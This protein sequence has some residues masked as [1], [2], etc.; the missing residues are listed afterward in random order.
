MPPIRCKSDRMMQINYPQCRKIKDW[1]RRREWECRLF[2]QKSTIK[3]VSKPMLS[4][5]SFDSGAFEP[6]S[7]GSS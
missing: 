5:A 3:W 6:L 1:L 2:T 7:P 4:E